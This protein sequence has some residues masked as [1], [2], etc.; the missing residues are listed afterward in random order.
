MNTRNNHVFVVKEG[1]PGVLIEVSAEHDKILNSHS[2]QTMASTI[3]KLSP[4]SDFSDSATDSSQDTIWITSDK[5]NACST[6]TGTIMGLAEAGV[7]HPRRWKT[8]TRSQI[9]RGGDRSERKRLLN[10]T[11]TF[12]PIKFKKE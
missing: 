8:E 12:T 9:R 7:N 5:V 11:G 4:R 10:E 6:T 3:P 1:K 2:R